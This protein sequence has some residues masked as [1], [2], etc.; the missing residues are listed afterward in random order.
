MTVTVHTIA[1]RLPFADVLAAGLLAEAGGDPL[2]LAGITVLL[3]SQ[4]ARRTLRE[5]FLRRS[6][7]APLLLPRMAAIGDLDE[8][9]V[10]FAQ[11]AGGGLPEAA[12]IPP[13]IPPLRRRLLLTRLILAMPDASGK[14]RTPDQAARLAAELARLLDQVQTEGLGF[15]GLAGLVPEDYARHWQITLNF[16]QILTHHWP[17]LLAAEG[18]LDPT[19]RRNRLLDA[20]GR[21]WTENPPPG[22]IIAAGITGSIPSAA[23]LVAVVAGLP[24]GCAVL[25]GLDR[26]LDDASWAELDESHPQ[27]PLKRLL[28]TLGTERAAVTDWTAPDNG[29]PAAPPSRQRLI[30]EALRPART[31]HRWR[32]IEPL[33]P[34]AIAGVSRID[35]PGPREEALTIA[36]MMR[37]ALED[38]GRT[39]ALVTPDR[40]L[41]RRVAA[42]LGRWGI[43]VDDSAGRPLAVT[44]PGVFLRLCAEMV[45]EDFAPVPLLAA[46]KHPLSGAGMARVAFREGVRTLDL[47]VLRGVRPGP[48]LDGLRRIVPEAE[49]RALTP[50]LDAV[51]A[52]CAPFIALMARDEVP[53]ADLLEAHLR[54]AEALAA[55]DD[56]PGPLELWANRAGDVAAGFARDLAD[57]AGDLGAIAPRHYPALLDALMVGVPVREDVGTHPRLSILG[58]L[59]ARLQHADLMIVGGLNEDTWPPRLQADPWMSR[60]MRTSFGLPLPEQRVGHTAHDFAHLF[61]A[62]R[63]ALTRSEK[64]EGTP[65]VPSRW[66]LRLETVMAASGLPVLDGPSHYLDWA[67]RLD[68][69]TAF[70]PGERP[71]PRPPV[72]AR[73]IALSATRIE[74]WMRDPYAIY[75]QYILGL[76][77]LDPLDAEPGAKDYGTLVHKALETFTLRHPDALPDD[78]LGALLACGREVFET[79]IARPAVWAFWWPR[80]ERLA[81]WVV[82]QEAQRRADVRES[83]VEVKGSLDIGGFTVTATADRVDLLHDGT[84][85]ILD[86][87]TGT[88]PSKKEVAAGYAPQLPLEACIA[89]AG[90]FPGIPARDVSQLLYWHLSGNTGG[91]EEKSAGDDPAEL[92]AEALDGLRGLVA[93][94]NR[95]ETPYEARPHPGKA[96]RYSDYLHLARV[97]EWSAG[98]GEGD[99]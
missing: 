4:R 89:Q 3:P 1:P 15:E 63:V 43:M 99:D 12:D 29:S 74:T 78:A 41:A 87:K 31:T 86:Y 81:A 77:A 49:A 55:S 64:V 90:G 79:D 45:A 8:D 26:D 42:D 76:R 22:R 14:P 37:E 34:E 2:A 62:P 5:A 24:Q 51:E 23:R 92:A 65:T 11:A 13:A 39:C 95:P 7:G 97:K 57:S 61:C 59:E 93:A 35:C 47:Q 44:P 56:T 17:V 96:P 66:L 10:L 6:G 52:C 69:P 75:A 30:S 33:P 48:G 83:H 72:E 67:A 68:Q 71:A 82:K 53:F 38:P 36:L 54:M 94:F 84:L 21:A 73:P 40:D 28:D 27:Y 80:F 18:C 98:G 9:E 16:L 91:G 60:P 25:P 46:L 20:Q 32:D 50:W 19:E 85:A 58:P 88:P 70:V